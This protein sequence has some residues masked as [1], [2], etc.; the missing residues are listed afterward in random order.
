MVIIKNRDDSKAWL[1]WFPDLGSSGGDCTYLL[2]LEGTG[3]L[4][5]W[6]TD[7]VRLDGYN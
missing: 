1:V 5:N 2:S 6:C 7:T 3:G 4:G